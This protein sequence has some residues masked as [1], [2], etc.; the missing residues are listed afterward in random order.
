MRGAEL[1]PRVV[2]VLRPQ[3]DMIESTFSTAVVSGRVEPFDF[4]DAVLDRARYDFRDLLV[5]WEDVLGRDRITVHAYPDRAEQTAIAQAMCSQLGVPF[6]GLDLPA[7]RANA[8]L[9]YVQAELLRRYTAA[10]RDH[11]RAARLVHRPTLVR[12]LREVGGAP[13]RLSAAERERLRKEYAESNEWVA[14]RYGVTLRHREVRGDGN[15]PDVF[16]GDDFAA[17]AD[18]LASSMRRRMRRRRAGT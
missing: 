4:E 6:D 15:R 5:R 1:D 16:R 14:E 10:T 18:A 17:F 3:E 11:T 7:E 13:F 12:A 9:S 2:V 8:S